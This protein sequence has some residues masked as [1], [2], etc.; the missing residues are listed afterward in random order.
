MTKIIDS[1]ETKL[2]V[3]FLMLI[4]I[5]SGGTF[6]FTYSQTKS[7]L[8]EQMREELM[9]IAGVAATQIDGDVLSKLIP[10]DESSAKFIQIRDQ[11]VKIKDSNS[12]IMYLYTMRKDGSRVEFIVDADYGIKEDAALI[13]DVYEEDAIELING[14]SKISADTEFTTDEWGT[15]LSGYAPIKDSGG[16]TVAI[17]GV[18]M[19][20]NKV[21][22][23]QNFIGNTIYYIM[24]IG[25]LIA[26][27]I[28]GY[29]SVTIIK[30][31]KKLNKV[32]NEIS[33][34]NT[35]V[36]MDVKRDDEIG[37]LA[38]SFGRMAASLKIMMMPSSEKPVEKPKEKPIAK[39]KKE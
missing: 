35:N 15:V 13:G 17:I 32:A 36:Q 19:D 25:I 2:V 12:H 39:Q 29:F 28:I 5:I 18:D 11:L 33:T 16:K 23:R 8:K 10:G 7:A 4:L 38:E 30:D 26:A 27:I 37:E 9:S 22:E 24:G 1:L 34:G 6:V 14:F 21:I 20:S 3:S 31:I